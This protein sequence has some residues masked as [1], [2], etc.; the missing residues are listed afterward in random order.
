[1]RIVVPTER[2]EGLNS[3]ISEHFGRA[4]FFAV[5]DLDGEEVKLSFVENRG[6]HFGGMGHAAE[7]ILKLK[8]KAVIAYGMGPKAITLFQREGVALY[9]ANS[10]TVGEVISAFKK[11]FLEELTEGR[12]RCGRKRKV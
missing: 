3:K 2:A 9:K 11:G 10:E 4:R 8:P 12:H 7:L 1:M 5:V 6:E